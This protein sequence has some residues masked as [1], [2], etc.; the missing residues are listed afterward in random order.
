MPHGFNDFSFPANIAQASAWSLVQS[1]T[2]GSNATNPVNPVGLSFTSNIVAIGCDIS[3]SSRFFRAGYINVY[4]YNFIDPG[5]QTF[6]KILLLSSLLPINDLRLI[7]IPGFIDSGTY[8][9][10]AIV[11]LSNWVANATIKLWEFNP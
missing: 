4:R 3:A 8:P 6:P 9:F 2:V 5:S 11:N 7:Q 10:H 1:V